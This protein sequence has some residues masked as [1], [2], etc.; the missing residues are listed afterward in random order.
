MG[1][2]KR[3]FRKSEEWRGKRWLSRKDGNLDNDN[4]LSNNPSNPNDTT[5]CCDSI[6]YPSTYEEGDEL[7]K[8][9]LD[10]LDLSAAFTPTST[11]GVIVNRNNP[12]TH[13][14]VSDSGE[15]TRTGSTTNSIRMDTNF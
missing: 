5:F 12:F 1:G 4:G 3:T 15:T 13:S 11:E 2:N 14:P 8:Q 6:S 9:V 7:E 10:P